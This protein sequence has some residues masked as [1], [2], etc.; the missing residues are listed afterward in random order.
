MKHC[1]FTLFLV[2]S[3]WQTLA[4]GRLFTI[5][6]RCPEAVSALV[7]GV[8]QGLIQ[9]DGVMNISFVDNWSGM[10]YTTANGGSSTGAGTTRA[11]FFADAHYYYIIKDASNFNTGVSIIPNAAS[12]NGFCETVI[13]D[14]TSC[15]AVFNQTPPSFPAP[16]DSPPTP[17]LFQCPSDSDGYRVVFCPERTFPP[18]AGS[19]SIHPSASANKCVDVRGAQ[20]V[21]GTTV[22]IWD[23]NNTPA[24]NWVFAVD[25]SKGSIKLAGTQ[26][27]LDAGAVP[28]SGTIL[29][30]WQCIDDL[31][32]QTWS[33]MNGTHFQLDGTSAFYLRIVPPMLRLV[34]ILI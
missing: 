33:L 28:A 32:A 12:S 1:P 30:L 26:F 34:L 19:L 8:S 6:N 23:C 10:I 5:V 17:P 2:T 13:C 3:I 14:S 29:K 25:G 31:P 21:N 9:Q 20:F 4:A 16:T 27:C 18:P 15:P 24:Q 7:N 11:G 22:Q